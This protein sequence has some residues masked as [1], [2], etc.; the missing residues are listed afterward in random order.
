MISHAWPVQFQPL[1]SGLA[2][3]TLDAIAGSSTSICRI[4]TSKE[5]N[6]FEVH[7]RH[8]QVCFTLPRGQAVIGRMNPLLGLG[9]PADSSRHGRAR[10]SFHE[11]SPLSP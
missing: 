4:S 10:I 1:L 7:A 11:V 3:A 9:A 8:G 5:L 6:L 2:D